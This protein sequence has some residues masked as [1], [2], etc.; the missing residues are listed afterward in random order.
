MSTLPI[1]PSVCPHA[2]LLA[3]RGSRCHDRG[4]PRAPG[5]RKETTHLR[6]EPERRG[7]EQ[8]GGMS[9][10]KFLFHHSPTPFHD[11]SLA[12]LVTIVKMWG[13]PKCPLTDRWMD[14]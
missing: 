5:I 12:A 11:Q 2:A 6:L 10:R 4:Q 7:G 13:Q 14:G 3:V 1:T 9:G 8:G